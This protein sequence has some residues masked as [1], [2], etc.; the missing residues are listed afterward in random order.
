M[1]KIKTILY[2]LS[3]ILGFGICA[4][5]ISFGNSTACY[6][7]SDGD[8]WGNPNEF[9]RACS[10]PPGYVRTAPDSDDSNPNES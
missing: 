3:L 1:K 10:C 9:V 8:G 2:L 7:D 5:W 6:R 4:Y